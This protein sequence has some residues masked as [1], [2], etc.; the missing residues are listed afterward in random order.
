MGRIGIRPGIDIDGRQIRASESHGLEIYCLHPGLSGVGDIMEQTLPAGLD[1]SPASVYN[2][3]LAWGG[4][5][6]CLTA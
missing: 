4:E 3:R 6:G 5:C 2:R 1:L